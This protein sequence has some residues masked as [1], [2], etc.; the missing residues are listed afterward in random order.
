MAIRYNFSL[1]LLICQFFPQEINASLRREQSFKQALTQVLKTHSD[2]KLAAAEYQKYRDLNFTAKLNYLPSINIGKNFNQ[3]KN[4]F[5]KSAGYL[6]TELNLFNGFSDYYASKVASVQ[7]RLYLLRLQKTQRALELKAATTFFNY[8]K[9]YQNLA[10]FKKILKIKE[11]SL[12]TT[13]LRYKKGLMSKS[14]GI[15]AAID[16]A[17]TKAQL[18]NVSI[19]FIA[20]R[21]DLLV[22]FEHESI[23]KN[24]PFASSINKLNTSKLP[25]QKKEQKDLLEYKI[26]NLVLENYNNQSMQSRARHYPQINLSY[27][28]NISKSDTYTENNSN[29]LLSLS[30]SLFNR[31]KDSSSNIKS[32]YNTFKQKNYQYELIKKIDQ[33]LRSSREKLIKS[34]QVIKLMQETLDLSRT[35]YI[36]NF[37]RFKSGRVSVNDLQQDQNRLLNSEQLYNEGLLQFH[38]NYLDYCFMRDRELMKCF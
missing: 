21:A 34:L 36:D 33:N 27:N 35:L 19:D 18:D 16:F 3:D 11:E 29:A 30:F 13:N 28:Y 12:N 20:A 37:K 14:D 9:Q 17:N 2:S 6:Q 25:L 26:S 22:M 1:L 10:I 31:G 24:W 5:K 32:A 23:E 15:K 8:I 7:E 4:G 38:L